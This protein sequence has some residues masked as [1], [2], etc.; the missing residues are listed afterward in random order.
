[1]WVR[2]RDALARDEVVM[3]QADRVMPGQQGARVP[4]LGGHLLMPLGPIKLALATGAPIIPIFSHRTAIGRLRVTIER[5]IVVG[6]ADCVSP[7]EDRAP[8][9]L[10]ALG[11]LIEQKVRAHPEQWFMLQ[12]ALCEDQHDEEQSESAEPRG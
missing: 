5:P 2:L 4:F 10:A 7:G 9:A 11:A 6:R 12:P 3:I 8:P 1:M